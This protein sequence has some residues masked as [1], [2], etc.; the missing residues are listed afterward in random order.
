MTMSNVE[1]SRVVLNKM[2]AMS[3]AETLEQMA[4]C[5]GSDFSMALEQ[6]LSFSAHCY[7]T[8]KQQQLTGYQ[9]EEPITP[10]SLS[11]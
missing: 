6:L 2:K 10:Y 11:L 3:V 7:L 4:A 8:Y 5:R 9:F 1:A